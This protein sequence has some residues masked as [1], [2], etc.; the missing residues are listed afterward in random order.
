[1]ASYFRNLFGGSSNQPSAGP[2]SSAKSHSRSHSAMPN[3]YAPGSSSGPAHPAMYRSH[4]HTPGRAPT[5]SP[6]RPATASDTR[7][8]YG[9]GRR[10]SHSSHTEP[11]MRPQVLRRESHRAGDPHAGKYKSPLP[12]INGSARN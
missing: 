7:T 5:S 4:S 3:I 1:M 9:Y 10:G 2:S 11:A 12:G 8:T 6:L